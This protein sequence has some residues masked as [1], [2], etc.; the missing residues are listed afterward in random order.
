MDAVGIEHGRIYAFSVLQEIPP[1]ARS[2]LSIHRVP[3]AQYRHCLALVVLQVVALDAV[4]APSRSVSRLAVRN[5]HRLVAQAS[6]RVQSEARVA[7]DA[8]AI[9]GVMGLAKG[10]GQC[11][12]LGLLIQIVTSGALNT[13]LVGL[14]DAVGV[15]WAAGCCDSLGRK[16][17]L[18]LLK[19]VAWPARLTVRTFVVDGLA[20]G[21]CFLHWPFRAMSPE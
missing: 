6:A 13:E 8:C 1:M 12:G 14:F 17:T 5:L 10:V 15:D 4:A 16:Q 3:H 21:F 19:D 2:A 7:R 9:L 11:A 18:S 20:Q